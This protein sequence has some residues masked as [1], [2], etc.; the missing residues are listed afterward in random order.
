MF[1][2]VTF[3]LSSLSQYLFLD[4]EADSFLHGQVASPSNPTELGL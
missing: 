1:S 4:L 3:R 2:S